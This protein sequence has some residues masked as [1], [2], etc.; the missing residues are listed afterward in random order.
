MKVRNASGHIV[1]VTDDPQ[2]RSLFKSLN[3]T[4]VRET[5]P[6]EKPPVIQED[7]DSPGGTL[8][9]EDM[10]SKTRNPIFEDLIEKVDPSLTDP[11]EIL[12]CI[13]EMPGFDQFTLEN[14]EEF[15]QYRDAEAKD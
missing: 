15:L 11:E 7:Y 8:P 3:L 13:M 12:L 9:D 14:V 6:V 1:E 10:T 4:P 2:F 5:E